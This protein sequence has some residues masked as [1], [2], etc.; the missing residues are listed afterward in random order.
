MALLCH[1]LGTRHGREGTG[2]E[3]GARRGA[4][5]GEQNH[6]GT[7]GPGFG[8]IFCYRERRNPT[9]LPAAGGTGLPCPAVSSVGSTQA[10][11][12]AAGS[13]GRRVLRSSW[14]ASISEGSQQVGLRP[15][16]AFFFP[17]A[18]SMAAGGCPSTSRVLE[19]TSSLRISGEI[20]GW[21]WNLS[22]SSN[23]SF[24]SEARSS[25]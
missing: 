3:D 5:G 2:Q 13:R 19:F 18:H 17:P 1:L 12:G 6:P 16:P 21:L 20:C 23:A 25:L 9:A 10:A 11:F 15:F 8:F 24:C 4:T 7:E 14:G 22:S